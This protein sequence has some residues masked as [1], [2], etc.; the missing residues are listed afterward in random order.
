MWPAIPKFCLLDATDN[1]LG[2]EQGKE[3]LKKKYRTP[4][5]TMDV[6]GKPIEIWS[7]PGVLHQFGV[8]G[9]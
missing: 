5:V 2:L 6:L 9:R 7:V 3:L 4:H 1:F 8:E